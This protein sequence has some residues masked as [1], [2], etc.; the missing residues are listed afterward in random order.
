MENSDRLTGSLWG[1]YDFAREE[2]AEDLDRASRVL[3]AK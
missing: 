2:L 1:G 3:A